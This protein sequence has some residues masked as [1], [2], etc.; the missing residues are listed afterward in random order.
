MKPTILLSYDVEEF[1]MPME[2]GGSIDLEEQLAISTNGLYKLLALLNKYGIKCTFYCT[3]QYALH[4]RELIQGLHDQ[5]FEI[6]SHGYYHSNFELAHLKTSKEVL[7][8]LIQHPV[9]GYRMARMMPLPAKA[10]ADA[11]YQYNSSINPTWIPGRYNNLSKPRTS[12]V[13]EGVLQFPASVTPQFRIPLFWLGF[14]NYPLSFYLKCSA[15]V[16]KKD[17][18]LNIYFHP[19]EFENYDG[20]G[21]ATFPK[22]VVR[23]SGALMLQRTESLIKWAAERGYRFDTTANWLDEKGLLH[24]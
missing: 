20:V 9:R 18:Y 22:Y 21:G 12:F 11:G 1:D 4:R 10:V 3:A 17:G 13:E 15:A 19:W 7:Q 23:N 2:Y 8:G 16:L 24:R 5:G 14:H 6:A